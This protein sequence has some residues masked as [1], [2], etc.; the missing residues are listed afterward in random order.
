[1]LGIQDV[2]VIFKHHFVKSLFHDILK[3][4]YP[5]HT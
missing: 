3:L 2:T 4:P 1:M 5:Q